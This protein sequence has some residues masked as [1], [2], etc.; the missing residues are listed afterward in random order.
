MTDTAQSQTGTAETD[1][2]AHAA[3]AFKISLGQSESAERP[4]DEHGR[5]ASTQTPVEA[6]EEEEIEAEAQA[7]AE[8]HEEVEE[9]D[10][11]A[12][13]AQPEAVDLPN[14]WPAE[15]AEEWKALPPETQAFIAEREGQRDAAVNAK[16][17]EA[18]NL[19]K[20]HEAEINEAKTN[21]TRYAEAIETVLGLV[22]P[23][24]PDPYQ[25]GLGT[26][27]YNREAYDVAVAQFEQANGVIETL[28]AQRE[29]LAAQE[30]K[31]A[32]REAEAAMAE[33]EAR[34]RA[35]FM[36]AYPDVTDAAKAGAFFGGLVEFAVERGLPEHLFSEGI[37]S[38]SS[39]EWHILADA[40]AFR[41]LQA[42]KAR[43]DTSAKPEPRK[44]QP[45]VRPGVTTPRSAIERA[46]VKKDVERLD[47]EG[48]VEA[49][50]A[51]WKHL[52]KGSK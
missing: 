52:L 12:E 36:Q 43:V 42:A 27:N 2:I 6:T 29:D 25:Y 3:Q 26:G 50:A 19:R 46:T 49:G 40:H 13:E 34:A 44:P 48:S 15:R 45:A 22:Q 7:E 33:I 38:I 51:I 5:F 32:V 14:S 9:T 20:A 47:R 18:A 8:S 1:A 10:E 16:F 28:K 24:R 21:R 31:E 11:A 23:Q 35:P 37:K 30:A 39:A 17:Q 41:K 4:R